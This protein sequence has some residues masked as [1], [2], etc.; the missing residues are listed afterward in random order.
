MTNPSKF[1]SS[2]IIDPVASS[3]VIPGTIPIYIR[4][5]K[6]SESSILQDD[7]YHYYYH[8]YSVQ[9]HWFLWTIL[10]ILNYRLFSP[11]KTGKSTACLKSHISTVFFFLLGF[12]PCMEWNGMELQEKEAQKD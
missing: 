4:V 5:N 6:T 3:E 7:Y 8:L 1:T 12:T 2:Q 10:T 11:L 9:R